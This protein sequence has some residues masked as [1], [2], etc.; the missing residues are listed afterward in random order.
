MISLEILKVLT[1]KNCQDTLQ[2]AGE[3]AAT[4]EDV[5]EWLEADGDPDNQNLTE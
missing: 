4:I 3:R 1:Q 2:L 5:E